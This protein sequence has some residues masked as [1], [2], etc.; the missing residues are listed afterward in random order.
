MNSM[1]NL[2][3]LMTIMVTILSVTLSACSSDDDV[4]PQI[5]VPTGNENFFE[6]SMDF[7]SLR[8]GHVF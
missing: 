4:I 2:W 6:K 7:E 3:S 1:K 5:S 8:R